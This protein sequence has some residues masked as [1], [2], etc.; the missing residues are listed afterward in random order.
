M[1]INKKKQ[2]QLFADALQNSFSKEFRNIHRK[3]PVLES[4]FKGLQLY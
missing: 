4:L 2:K 3:T 1:K